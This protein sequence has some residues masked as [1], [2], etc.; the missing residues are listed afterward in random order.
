[1]GGGNRGKLLWLIGSLTPPPD[2]EK[3]GGYDRSP[4][5]PSASIV[6]D[7]GHSQMID[8]V[9]RESQR[10]GMRLLS[11]AHEAGTVVEGNLKA[12]VSL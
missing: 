6:D 3:K 11:G 7:D 8:P 4:T 10:L 12:R 5:S 9:R 1:M 2:Q